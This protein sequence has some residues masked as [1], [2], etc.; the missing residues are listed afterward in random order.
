MK[1][2]YYNI[3]NLARRASSDG[4]ISASGLVGLGFDPGGVVNSHL[5]IFNLG[6]RRGGD[7]HFLIVRLYIT[8]LD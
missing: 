8:G 6:A 1:K 5:E 4:S 7:V 2:L 3:M